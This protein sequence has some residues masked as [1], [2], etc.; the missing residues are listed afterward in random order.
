MNFFPISI[1]ISIQKAD[2]K[3]LNRL[4]KIGLED[5]EILRTGLRVWE[6]RKGLN[7]INVGKL[8]KI[9]F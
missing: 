7:P 2:K 4:N 9:I 5:F 3:R 6:E 8:F 1:T